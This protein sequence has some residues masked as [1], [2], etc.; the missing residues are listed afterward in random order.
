M[1]SKLWLGVFS[2]ALTRHPSTPG[3]KHGNQMVNPMSVTGHKP[4]QISN[5]ERI[6][7]EQKR[8][9]EIV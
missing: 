7:K 1:S 2:L 8:R 6:S 4:R 3:R 9:K 5:I